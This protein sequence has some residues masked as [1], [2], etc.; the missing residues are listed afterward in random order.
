MLN[1]LIKGVGVSRTHY[2][3]SPNHFPR[4]SFA[5]N[6]GPGIVG[7]PLNNSA[8]GQLLAHRRQLPPF[9]ILE[10]FNGSAP[11][12]RCERFYPALP[13]DFFYDCDLQIRDLHI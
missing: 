10:T 7:E 6:A 2:C 5:F 13:L 3:P 4:H 8:N 9:Y 12:Y 11:F 1:L